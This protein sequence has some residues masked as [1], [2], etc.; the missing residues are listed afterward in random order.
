MNSIVSID[1]YLTM[2]KDICNKNN[3]EIIDN[4][5][6]EYD[7]YI[8]LKYDKSN[9]FFNNILT[10]REK[11][12]IYHFEKNEL[13]ISGKIDLYK[14][15]SKIE[16]IEPVISKDI[17]EIITFLNYSDDSSEVVTYY[18]GVSYTYEIY[19]LKYDF[20]FTYNNFGYDG[21][22]YRYQVKSKESFYEILKQ[23]NKNINLYNN[24]MNKVEYV[25]DKY[26]YPK[27]TYLT[28]LKNILSKKD[29][30]IIEIVNYDNNYY[31]KIEI[32]SKKNIYRYDNNNY[33][34]NIIP[35]LLEIYLENSNG[36]YEEVKNY[37]LGRAFY[38][39]EINPRMKFNFYNIKEEELDSYLEYIK[40][41]K[42]K[43]R[44]EKNYTS[45][46]EVLDGVIKNNYSYGYVNIL[47]LSISV[48]LF[49]IFIFMI[50][51]NILR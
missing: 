50:T 14:E 29:D 23:I 42:D 12:Y 13:T 6:L 49:G 36:K 5:T 21:N 45:D 38:N 15:L 2:I 7:C 3:I 10:L 9:S 37:C 39:N 25:K 31:L 30:K 33:F 24:F 16:N 44:K 17:E 28:E 26:A 35:E 1:D 46:A 22:R 20:A 51:L 19:S 11:E 8:T 48:L 27:N 18:N 32:N 34:K 41:L 47:L 40:I 43:I 4:N